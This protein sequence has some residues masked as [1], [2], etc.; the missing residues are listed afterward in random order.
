MSSRAESSPPVIVVTAIAVGDPEAVSNTTAA[1]RRQV[2]E[3]ARV[4]I[5]GGDADARRQ[6]EGDGVAWAPSL[7]ALVASLASDVTHV[8]ILR[9]GAEP[10]PDALKALVEESERNNAAIAGSKLVRRDAPEYLVSVGLAT[11]VF[12]VPYLGLDADEIDAGQY[13]VVRDVAAVSGASVLIRRDLARG[14]AGPDPRLAPMPAAVDLAQRARLRGARVVVVPSS[15]VLIDPQA[16]R[17]APWREEAG[18]IRAMLKVYSGLTLAWALPLSFLIGLLEAVVAPFLGRFTLHSWLAAWVWNLF[19]LPSTIRDRLAARRGRVTDD[20]ELFRFQL[21]GSARLRT[22]GSEVALKMRNRLGLDEGLNLAEIGRDLRSPAVVVGLLSVLFGLFASRGIWAGALPQVGYSLHLP[23]DG[24]NTALSYA[25]GWNP[26]GMGSAEPL[27]PF[28]GFAGLLQVVLFDNPRVTMSVL[29]VASVLFGLWG[30]ARLF[31]TFGI[32]TPAAILG[33]AVLL[34]GP[35]GRAL[36]ADTAVTTWL[37]LGALPWVIRT[38]MAPWPDGTGRRVGRVAAGAWIAGLVG[39]AAPVLLMLPLG[40]V[41]VWWL[42]HPMDRRAGRNVAVG[43]ASTALAVPL[44]M[45]WIGH[46]DLERYLQQGAAFW[47]PGALVLIALAVAL[48]LNVVAAESRSASVSIWGGLLVA[49]GVA[50]ART[51]SL[52][53][54]REVEHLGM[55][56]VALGAAAIVA[57]TFDGFRRFA[58]LPGWK[59]G[60]GAVAGVAAVVVVASTLLVSV[61]GRMGLPGTRF[62]DALGF[63]ASA[64][65]DPAASRVLV[66][67]PPDELPGDSQRVRGAAYRVVSAPLPPLTEA[68]LAAPTIADRELEVVLNGLIG[69]ETARAGEALATFGVRWVVSLG[70]TPLE[71]VFAGQLDMLPLGTNRLALTYDGPP[72]IRAT[73][74]AGVAWQRYG[75]GYRGPETDELVLLAETA[76]RRWGPEWTQVGWQSAV[77]GV[78]GVASFDPIGGRRLE[79]GIGAALFALLLAASLWG[80]RS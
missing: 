35:G 52:G 74:E 40:A 25:G 21:R 72:P 33:G 32:D 50:L 43:A 39:I 76:N 66:I 73:T 67:G 62:D 64:A 26:A 20:A 11:D 1:V 44:L 23:E 36:M 51:G 70:E 61:P 8:W 46:A 3:S 22:L 60:V 24:L 2:Y 48:V 15:E 13:D 59:K 14:V 75:T 77:S 6:A 19:R 12:D 17:A 31:R 38:M 57:A 49:A 16:T 34:A 53:P 7:H 41:L 79:A 37:A 78:D 29:V 55:A 80:R 68:W 4:V 28:F 58:E 54:G 18:R 30:S 71:E 47:T 27:R 45:P 69:G 56:A 10:R 63:I 65:G 42:L 9:A 5:V